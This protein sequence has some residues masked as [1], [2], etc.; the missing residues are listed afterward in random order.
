MLNSLILFYYHRQ[1][2][3]IMKGKKH[4]SDIPFSIRHR[5]SPLYTMEFRKYR[6]LANPENVMYYLFTL[7]IIK[8]DIDR[9]EDERRRRPLESIC[10]KKERF[11]NARKIDILSMQK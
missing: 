3:L 9:I 5:Y 2:D 1:S 11:Y 4:L 10:E 6:Y 7:S 8:K